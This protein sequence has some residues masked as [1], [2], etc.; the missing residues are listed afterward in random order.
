MNFDPKIYKRILLETAMREEEEI[1]KYCEEK[2]EALAISLNMT[3][4]I[5]A[6]KALQACRFNKKDLHKLNTRI[7]DV[8]H[9]YIDEILE[10]IKK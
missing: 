1:S 9:D 6:M 3:I 4:H 2:C 8:Y 7:T 10:G 5:L